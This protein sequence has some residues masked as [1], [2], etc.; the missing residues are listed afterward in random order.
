[1]T[2]KL[3]KINIYTFIFFAVCFEITAQGGMLKYIIIL[4]GSLFCIIS[5]RNKISISNMNIMI[6]PITYII[7]G[8]FANISNHFWNYNSIKQFLLI[9][10]PS[11][12]AIGIYTVFHDKNIDVCKYIFWGIVVANIPSFAYFTRENLAESQYA[13]IY[14][15][16]ILYFFYMKDWKYE[17]F[18]VFLFILANKRISIGAAIFCIL[19]YI[20]LSRRKKKKLIIV[21]S[22]LTI[23]I[24]PYVYIWL[25]KN[26][27]ITLIFSKY[28]INSMGRIDM[29][30]NFSKYY[31]LSPRFIGEGIG[32]IF[33]RLEQINN[34][35]F[36]NLHNDLLA[37]F[38]EVGFIGFSMWLIGH[39]V[40]IYK[41]YMKKNISFKAICLLILLIGYTL[42]NYMTDNILLY[43][44]YWLPLNLIILKITDKTFEGE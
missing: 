34:V 38:L 35:A 18:C 5:Q 37:T 30:K 3:K 12:A 25:V 40:I 42:I 43:I 29:W 44:N 28:S 10:V 8:L 19:V 33:T 36:G 39:I 27:W 26:S 24:V 15:I 9:I 2:I 32:W 22:S 20:F 1:M 4:L 23:M 6:P 16:F 14:G 13:F 11:V 17:F 21:V 41:A 7:F 31:I